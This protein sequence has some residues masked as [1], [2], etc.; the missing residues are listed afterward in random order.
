MKVYTRGGDKGFTSLIGGERVKKYHH[1]IEAYG[2][3]DELNSFIGLIRDHDVDTHTFE[4]IIYIQDLIFNI[5]SR[6]AAS[7]SE[8]RDEL[9]GVQE[10]DIAFLEKEIDR[11]NESLPELTNFILPGGDLLV[12]YTHIARTICRRAERL[13]VGMN[14]AEEIDDLSLKFVNRLSDYFFTLAREFS[15]V[16]KAKEIIWNPKPDIPTKDTPTT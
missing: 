13:M 9:P 5:E 14:E 2:T 6:L 7:T 4:T 16:R 10:S 8:I 11:M 1:K 12:S 3:L 15:V